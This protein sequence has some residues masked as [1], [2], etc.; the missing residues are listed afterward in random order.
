MSNLDN[1]SSFNIDSSLFVSTMVMGFGLATR[2]ARLGFPTSDYDFIVIVGV[3]LFIVNFSTVYRILRPKTNILGE[4]A[5]ITTLLLS[6]MILVSF[7]SMNVKPFVFTLAITGFISLFFLMIKSKGDGNLSSLS[8]WVLIPLTLVIWILGQ[9]YQKEIHHP[10]FVE[11]I[12]MGIISV[13]QLFHSSITEM[14]RTYGIPSFGLYGTP[15]LPYHYGSHFVMAR[16]SELFGL[17]AL[18]TYNYVYPILFLPLYFRA[19]LFL[20]GDLFKVFHSKSQKP[21]SH[22]SFWIVLAMVTAGFLPND[23]L[24]KFGILESWIVSES[25]LLSITFLFLCISLILSA[26]TRHVNWRSATLETLL[27]IVLIIA[28]AFSKISVGFVAGLAGIYVLWRS[29]KWKSP[30]LI[31]Y[32]AITLI[33]II[34]SLKFASPSSSDQ[35]TSN[36]SFLYSIRTYTSEQLRDMFL[37]VYYLFLIIFVTLRLNAQQ[38]NSFARLIVSIRKRKLLDVEFLIVVAIMGFIPPAILFIGQGSGFYFLD[39]QTR[40]SVAFLMAW[41]LRHISCSDPIKFSRLT[42]VLYSV[43]V[44]LG[45]SFFVSNVFSKLEDFIDVNYRLRSAMIAEDPT[46]SKFYSASKG[47]ADYLGGD[48]TQIP[49]KITEIIELPAKTLFETSPAKGKFGFYKWLSDT[50]KHMTDKRNYYVAIP[51][52]ENFWIDGN[53][54]PESIPFMLPAIT[55]MAAYNGLP[56]NFNDLKLE[57]YYGFSAYKNFKV[58]S[59]NCRQFEGKKIINLLPNL[60]KFYPCE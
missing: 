37:F 41:F 6:I 45:I 32:G 9:M 46:R 60:H 14:I 48:P 35:G 20:V 31:M 49:Q 21:S 42:F 19:F 33:V 5:K 26:G 54:V 52:V 56:I 34:V 23:F 8:K 16:F 11:K 55:G 3:A 47:T 40:L 59:V 29:G 13:D 15:Y 43:V 18:E 58:D 44:I 57:N 17:K 25:Y 36:F 1:N 53:I 24:V 12:G 51:R 4:D 10:L 2:L 28:V 7:L 27:F 38:V 22:W 30:I 39:V 50:T